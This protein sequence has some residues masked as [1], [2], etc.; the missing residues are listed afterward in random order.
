MNTK[1]IEVTNLS[2]FQT[3]PSTRRFSTPFRLDWI[4]AKLLSECNEKAFE[5]GCKYILTDEIKGH[6]ERVSQWIADG[7]DKPWLMFLGGVG[8][9]KTTFAKG[10]HRY[11][12]KTIG[13]LYTVN[14]FMPKIYMVKAKDLHRL[15][16]LDRERF[17]EV[18]AADILTIDDLGLEPKEALEF[19]TVTTPIADLLEYRYDHGLMTIMTTNLDGKLLAEHYGARIYDRFKEMTLLLFFKTKSFRGQN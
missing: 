13:N 1:Q 6:L 7:N 12:Q 18:M 11:F 17:N 10:L 15:C 3:E 9:G 16:H 8:N 14:G 2:T 5:R 19:G 4:F